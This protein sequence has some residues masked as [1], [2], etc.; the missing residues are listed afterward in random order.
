MPTPPAEHLDDPGRQDAIADRQWL[1]WTWWLIGG[2]LLFRLIYAAIVPLDLVPDEAYYW[3]WSRQL[4]WGY[5]SKPPMVAWLIAL[6]TSL[7]GT[8]AFAVRLPAVLLGTL[9]LFWMYLLAAHLYGRKAGFWAAVLTAATP[10]NAALALLM[11]IDAPFLFCWC[12][13]LYCFWRFLEG[14]RRPEAWLAAAT[15]VT[16]LGLLSKQTM[17]GF[18]PLAFVFLL[19]SPADRRQLRKPRFWVWIAGSLLFLVPVLVWNMHHDWI[20]AQ[21]TSGHFTSPPVGILK[22]LSRFGE[23]LAGMF[24]G[25]TPVTM[26]LFAAVLGL[27]AHRFRKMDR[28]ARYLFCFSGLPMAGVL[29]LALVQRVQPNWPAGFVPAGLVL[30]CGWALGQVAGLRPLKAGQQGLRRAAVV[31]TI[32]ALVAYLVP[33]GFGLQGSRID[34][35]ARLRGWR[36]VGQAVDA[37][38]RQLPSAQDAF[39]ISTTG[40]AAASELAFYLPAQPRA[41]VWNVTGQ[42]QSQYD[43]WGGPQDRIGAASLIVTPP[44]SRPPEALAIA[45]ETVEPAGQVN[46]PLGNGRSHQYQLW[47]GLGFRGWPANHPV[48][49]RADNL[50][51]KRS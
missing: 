45:F 20:T 50:T 26:A 40:R 39:L 10:G 3:D 19:V 43:I 25:G 13:A 27:V 31:G 23:F 12:A 37:A 48:T 17:F 11:T 51:A 36:E 47:R 41:F 6:S 1:R 15:L 22:R 14:G 4:D 21:H 28:R 35:A 38:W 18:L 30:V 8:T 32:C 9:G 49:A 46:I 5:Y 16:G 33:L 34:P 7:A 2:L 44:D 42:M 24:G 29:G